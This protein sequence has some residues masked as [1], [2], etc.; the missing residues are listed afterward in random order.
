MRSPAYSATHYH[1]DHVGGD[2]FGHE[3]VGIAELLELIEVPITYIET[4][5]RG[6]SAPR[7][8]GAQTS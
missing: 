7:G 6:S 5:Q 8:S 1:S 3:I 2:L 4:R